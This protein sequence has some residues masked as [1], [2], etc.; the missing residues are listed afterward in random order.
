MAER[1]AGETFGIDRSDLSSALQCVFADLYG[2]QRFWRERYIGM[3]SYDFAGVCIHRSGYAA[4]SGGAGNHR[5]H[6]PVGVRLRIFTE[7]S[8]PVDVSEP[9]TELLFSAGGKSACRGLE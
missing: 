5:V 4:A 6:V 3:G 2:V 8:D 7:L 9:G 1:T